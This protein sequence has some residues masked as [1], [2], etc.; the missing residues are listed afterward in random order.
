M[1]WHFMFDIKE[2]T[3]LV[4][5]NHLCLSYDVFFVSVLGICVVSLEYFHARYDVYGY[6]YV[7]V[8]SPN[9]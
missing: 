2:S 6:I 7:T 1:L 9:C 3:F 8:I 5:L 4:Y